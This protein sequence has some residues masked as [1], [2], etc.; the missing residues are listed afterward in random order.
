MMTVETVSLDEYFKGSEHPTDI[1]KIDVEGA[2]LEVLLGMQ[3][4][5]ERYGKD[6]LTEKF[7]SPNLLCAKLPLKVSSH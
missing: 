2:E 6:A 1:V 7:L 5:L 3:I 4:L